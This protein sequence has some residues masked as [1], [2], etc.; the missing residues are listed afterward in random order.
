MPEKSY[1]KFFEET[2]IKDVP[3][4]GGKNASLGEMY[5][6][7]AGRGIKV[8]NGFATTAQAYN[9]LLDQT[10]L[11]ED[12]K[13]V[14]SGLNTRDVID[15]ARRGAAVRK[16]IVATAFPEDLSQD[17]IS[18]YKKLS[19]F[20]KTKNLHVAV[21]SSATA[22]DLP[23]ASFAGQQETFLN[24]SG[25][26]ELL[27][28]VKKCIASLF[29]N[30]AISYRVD[31]GFD[32]FKIALSVG[33]QKMIRSDLAASGVTFTIDT[34]SGFANAVLISSIY[35]LGENIVQGKVDPDEFYVFKPTK[36]IISRSVSSKK[37]K[38]VYSSNPKH[39]VKDVKVP[40]ADQRRQSITDAQVLELADWAM[41]IEKHYGRPMDIEWALDGEENQLYIIQARPETIH[42]VRDLSVIEE[43]VL[44]KKS[45]SRGGTSRGRIL[46]TGKS[47]G[48]RI[49]AG[50]A[51]RI[52]DISA[53]AKFKPGEVLVTDMTDPDWEPIMKIASAIV[54]DKGGR[55]CH[56][57]IVSRE[58]GIPCVVGTGDVSRK[59]KTGEKVTVSC[60]EGDLGFVYEGK[61]AF[62]INKTSIKNLAKP[63]TKIMMNIG[64]PDIAF[65]SS[66]IPN[67]GV[68]LAREEFIVNDQ[69]KI[70]PLALINYPKLKDKK[71][72]KKIDELTAGYK[73]KKQYYI[74]K[75]AQGV[76][77]LTAAFYPK[78]VIIR[79]SDFKTNEYA[80]LIGG[81][82][83]E[84]V[85][86]NPMIGWRGA[87][88]YYDPKYEPAFVLECLALKKV[89][90]EMGLKNLKVMVP[91]CRTVDEGKKVIEI[92]AKNGLKRHVDGLEIYVMAEIPTNIILAE[93]FAAVFDGFS[94]G[95]NDLTQLTLGIDRDSGILNVAGA[96]NE[97][98]QSVKDLIKNLILAAKKTNTKVGICGQ[99]PSDFPDFAQFLVE[100]GIDSISLNPDTV[101]KTTLAIL[102]TEKKIRS[103]NS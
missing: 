57:A 15:L 95:S 99:A 12:I 9:Y 24:V 22:E 63:K 26:A 51:N 36:T 73:D 30:R 98:N 6:N 60:A 21:R 81:A 29:T 2:T 93:Q 96:S 76:A 62:K 55:T 58:L 13:K 37:I 65:L 72:K 23:D 4:V 39:P 33:I 100:C 49:G 28:A 90:D 8:P 10:H 84:P 53:I 40:L 97:K 7:L 35:G 71:A 61:L 101:I 31:K 103:R 68:G 75:L 43:Y 50:V 20:Y 91:F 38:M 14:L 5:K 79:L 16:L 56:A 42:S 102:E 94:I 78:D 52:M 17:I 47:V 41:Q 59:I 67:D 25:E 54:T 92:M 27:L 34:E 70:H 18:S 74:D 86:A 87:S 1:I 89:R 83:Y 45:L 46:S 19:E 77:I 85:E 48:N 3:E 88:R 69:I 80:N 32:H 11:K 64:S 82:E 66:F 44:E